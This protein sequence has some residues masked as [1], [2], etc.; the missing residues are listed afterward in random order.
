MAVAVEAVGGLA[1]ASGT[2]AGLAF[3]VTAANKLCVGI[4]L[5]W[6]GSFTPLTG[7]TYNGVAMTPISGS[8]ATDSNFC[9]CRWY[10][11]DNPATGTHDILLTLSENVQWSV[12]AISYTG[13]GTPRT[14]SVRTANSTD[15]FV[16]VASSENGDIVMSLL[17]TDA[18]PGA[19]T[20]GGTTINNA[21][22]IAGDTDQVSQYQTAVGANTV[23]SWTST[24]PDLFAAS[25]VAIPSQGG[26][27]AT[28]ILFVGSFGRRRTRYAI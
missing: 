22:D 28:Q 7:V 2:P 26:T 9:A 23:C 18:A 13:A 20:P 15:P 27:P 6:D 5:G 8:D 11:L 3:T 14:P 12:N 24:Q 10:Q 21:Q 17:V 1:G 4:G 25:G 16:T 19:N